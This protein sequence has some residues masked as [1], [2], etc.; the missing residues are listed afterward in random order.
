MPDYT[1]PTIFKRVP[2]SRPGWLA[3]G[4]TNCTHESGLDVWLPWG[5]DRWR[6]RALPLERF[7][8]RDDAMLAVEVVALACGWPMIEYAH[9]E[10][11]GTIVYS[12]ESVRFVI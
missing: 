8:T 11:D 3:T 12:A 10:A 6:A 2:V 7:V 4:A 9:M 5:E 1:T